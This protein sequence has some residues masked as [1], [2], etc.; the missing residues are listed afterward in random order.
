MS[1]LFLAGLFSFLFAPPE[2]R[3]EEA[4][5]RALQAFMGSAENA[6]AIP[7][8]REAVKID[9]GHRDAS[10]TLA[11]Y[12]ANAGR[13]EE[14]ERALAAHLERFPDDAGGWHEAGKRAADAR[15]HEK[16]CRLY[17]KAVDA[18]PDAFASHLALAGS[19][20]KLGRHDEAVR[21]C[22]IF[23]KF[24]PDDDFALAMIGQCEAAAGNPD[25]AVAALEASL[26]ADPESFVVPGELF[27]LYVSAGNP[28]AALGIARRHPCTLR[29]HDFKAKNADL[30]VSLGRAAQAHPLYREAAEILAGYVSADEVNARY[31][32]ILASLLDRWERAGGDA[33][34]IAKFRAAA[35]GQETGE[36]EGVK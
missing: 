27:D 17:R 26:A 32:P 6:D 19:L 10:A 1:T 22:K 18:D 25:A 13:K 29:T 34:E 15:D 28:E 5:Q 36:S 14:A 9:P 4:Y 12:L 33:G 24:Q 31:R 35:S 30:L 21:H 16:A 11:K 23:L 7:H 20:Q 8:L 2:Q 3:A